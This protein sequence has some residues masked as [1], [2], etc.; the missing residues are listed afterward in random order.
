VSNLRYRFQ[1]I[2]NANPRD[3]EL[4]G[5]CHEMVGLDEPMEH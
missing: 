1:F 3:L 4:K 2:L 5:Q